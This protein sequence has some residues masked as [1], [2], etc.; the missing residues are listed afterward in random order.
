MNI[1]ELKRQ[2]DEYS[3][4]QWRTVKY[5]YPARFMGVLDRSHHPIVLAIRQDDG[6][7][8]QTLCD[9]LSYKTPGTGPYVERIT[10]YMD[11]PIDAQIVVSNDGLRWSRAHFAG[12]DYRGNPTTWANHGTSWSQPFG[13]R[14]SWVFA[15]LGD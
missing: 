5:H 13:D 10:P 11:W 3:N 6:E 12:T 14:E 7:H 9:D 8:I 4:Y 15:A 1:D 2:V